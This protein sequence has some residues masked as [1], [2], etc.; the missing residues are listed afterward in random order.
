M[1]KTFYFMQL[2]LDMLEILKKFT[3][4]WKIYKF[5]LIICKKFTL[6]I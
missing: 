4:F 1:N 6:L 3:I 2:L 5:I